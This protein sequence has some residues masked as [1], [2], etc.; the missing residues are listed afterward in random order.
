MREET[1][2][3]HEIAQYMG[4]GFVDAIFEGTTS[5]TLREP[6]LE[7]LETIAGACRDNKT[8]PT[9]LARFILEKLNPAGQYNGERFVAYAE[10]AESRLWTVTFE[11]F[12]GSTESVTVNRATD[13]T[14]AAIFGC[15]SMIGRK[16][17]YQRVVSVEEVDHE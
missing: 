5:E 7:A 15:G 3:K 9:T 4:W 13:K 16:R 8:I 17:V 2:F 11:M 1:K 12:D 10:A 6:F 14:T